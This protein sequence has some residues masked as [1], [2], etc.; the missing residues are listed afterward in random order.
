[1][2]VD[3][4]TRLLLIAFFL[5][6]VAAAQQPQRPV[7]RDG[8]LKVGDWGPDFELAVRGS[9][10]KVRLSSFRGRKPVALVFGSYT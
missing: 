1:L 8:S 5:A 2:I 3:M 4:K 6:S 9:T 7:P 10:Q